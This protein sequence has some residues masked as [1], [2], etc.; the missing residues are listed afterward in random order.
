MCFTVCAIN[1]GQF[2]VQGLM[3]LN[4]ELLNKYKS[5]LCTQFKFRFKLCGSY[6]SGMLSSKLQ[7][8]MIVGVFPCLNQ[9]LN[10]VQIVKPT[11][12]N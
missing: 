4:K 7:Y 11:K 1:L 9:V 5:S 2:E 12:V 3:N 8:N 6:V 10:V